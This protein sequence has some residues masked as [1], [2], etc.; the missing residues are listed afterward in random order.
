VISGKAPVAPAA[1]S[2]LYPASSFVLLWSWI[3]RC[4]LS[5]RVAN[6]KR[7]E[8]GSS[9]SD[10]DYDFYQMTETQPRADEPLLLFPLVLWHTSRAF[11]RVLYETSINRS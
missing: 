9:A 5:I 8:K 4:N 2:T 10:S 3:S 6:N 11:R 7:T 1:G